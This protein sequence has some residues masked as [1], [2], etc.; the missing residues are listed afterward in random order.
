MS[1]LS[2]DGIA[3]KSFELLEPLSKDPEF[4]VHAHAYGDDERGYDVQIV[5]DPTKDNSIKKL[6]GEAAE[7]N[8]NTYLAFQKLLEKFKGVANIRTSPFCYNEKVEIESAHISAISE[9]AED[10]FIEEYTDIDFTIDDIT[11]HSSIISP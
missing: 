6:F 9:S 1:N 2:E 4:F 5:Q 10:Y 8:V 11:E 7:N 3:E